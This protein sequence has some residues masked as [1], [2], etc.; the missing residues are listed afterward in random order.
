P[1]RLA[2]FDDRA[3][4]GHRVAEDTREGAEVQTARGARGGWTR[5]FRPASL[6]LRTGRELRGISLRWVRF[7]NSTFHR[8]LW[9]IFG[10]WG[11]GGT[12]GRACGGGSGCSAYLTTGVKGTIWSQAGCA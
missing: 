9:G 5:R 1:D 2:A 7:A 12:F 8:A 6:N 4:L 10:H 3:G 11:H